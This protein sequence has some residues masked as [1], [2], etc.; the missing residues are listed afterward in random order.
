MNDYNEV[1]LGEGHKRKTEIENLL[2][3][4]TSMDS[5]LESD[6]NDVKIHGID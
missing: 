6:E 5:D 3:P 2:A 1:M 4:I